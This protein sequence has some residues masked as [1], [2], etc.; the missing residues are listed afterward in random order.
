MAVSEKVWHAKLSFKKSAC[1]FCL[2]QWHT[3]RVYLLTFLLMTVQ[4]LRK[5]REFP[6]KK[7]M[8]LHPLTRFTQKAAW[9]FSA[10]AST[11]HPNCLPAAADG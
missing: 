9:P 4:S 1:H 5:E 2:S 10:S 3:T 7:P 8:P 6:F 11:R